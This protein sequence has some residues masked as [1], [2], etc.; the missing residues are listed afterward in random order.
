MGESSWERLYGALKALEHQA[1]AARRDAKQPESRREAAKQ[2]RR[3]HRQELGQAGQK[4]SAWVPREAGAANVPHDWE[5]LWARCI[6]HW[7]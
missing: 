3:I 2:V 1:Q 5:P 6:N 4:I 7:R